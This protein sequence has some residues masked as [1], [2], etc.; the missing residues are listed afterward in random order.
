MRCPSCGASYCDSDCCTECGTVA[1]SF[2]ERDTEQSDSGAFGAISRSGSPQRQHAKRSTLIEFPGVVR[3]TV[4]DWRRELSERVKEVHERRAREAAVEAAEAERERAAQAEV[5]PTPPL[6]LLPQT[7]APAINPLVAAALRRIERANKQI[8]SAAPAPRSSTGASAAALAYVTEVE[9]ESSPDEH[10]ATI[11]PAF[12]V[13]LSKTETKAQT[14][15]IHNL[16][17]V[18]AP[19]SATISKPESKIVARR[20]ISE[21]DPALN[22]LD[23]IPTTLR[24][25]EIQERQAGMPRRI[26]GALID[27]LVA[28]VLF[29]PFAAAV[30]LTNGDWHKLRTEAITAAV[31]TAVY[32][33]YLTSATA[34][35]GRTLGMRALSLR[36]IDRRT[37]LI[38]TGTQCAGRAL[39]SLGS[40]LVLG[41]PVIYALLDR[42]GHTA[43]DRLTRTV[44]VRI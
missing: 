38:P 41:F 20:L 30:E 34:L 44:V 6:E 14:E 39:I 40:L 4:P 3:S 24:V 27:L 12:E 26:V 29:S 15:R 25:E 21:N 7:T 13:D 16:V 19:A 35:T 1:L 36:T 23:S 37:G 43:H 5:A 18:P 9:L 33:L 11:V 31:A 2:A 32:F 10:S 17:V 8:A 22:Y 42:E 28:A